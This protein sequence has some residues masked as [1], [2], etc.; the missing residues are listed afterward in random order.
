MAS[1]LGSNLSVQNAACYTT[2]ATSGSLRNQTIYN[3]LVALQCV[4]VSEPDPQKIEI[5]RGSGSETKCVV[6]L[7][8]LVFPISLLLDLKATRG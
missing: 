1:N 2:L 8:R 6:V 5:F 7:L 4:V 3:V